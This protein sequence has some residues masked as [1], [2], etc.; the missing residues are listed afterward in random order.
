MTVA[1]D[2]F[3]SQSVFL[4]FFAHMPIDPTI[5][6]LDGQ[7]RRHRRCGLGM[8]GGVFSL[9]LEPRIA[10]N[11][12]LYFSRIGSS[13][14]THE[15]ATERNSVRYP[16]PEYTTSVQFS[17]QERGISF[18]FVRWLHS[19]EWCIRNEKSQ[20]PSLECLRPPRVSGRTS[21]TQY[22]ETSNRDTN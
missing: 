18:F 7:S 22:Q 3:L 2:V 13:S 4:W 5:Q 20:T 8:R 15:F 17:C 16:C 6:L 1:Q 11:S 19:L 10:T 12:W 14:A 21:C 9:A